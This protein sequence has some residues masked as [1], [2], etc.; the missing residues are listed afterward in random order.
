MSTGN[1]IIMALRH[2]LWGVKLDGRLQGIR[3]SKKI[4]AFWTEN[5]IMKHEMELF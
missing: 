1:Q 4:N 2:G 5:G 3:I